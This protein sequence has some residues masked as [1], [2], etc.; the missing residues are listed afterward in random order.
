MRPQC[1]TDLLNDAR[2]YTN[3]PKAPQ[4][5]FEARE[6]PT[7]RNRWSVQ[8]TTQGDGR[9]AVKGWRPIDPKIA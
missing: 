6:C 9:W 2:P 1:C 3:V 5:W 4:D 7:C 8:F